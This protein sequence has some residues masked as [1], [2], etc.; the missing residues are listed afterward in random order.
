MVNPKELQIA[1]NRL[2]SILRHYIWPLNVVESIAELEIS[3]YKSMPDTWEIKNKLN[4]LKYK[5]K[6]SVD[7]EGQSIINDC[8]DK[9]FDI[10]N[11]DDTYYKIYQVSEVIQ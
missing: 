4:S 11:S 5:I 7:D 1:Y 3:I 9:I 10:C 2:Y 6:N 8:I